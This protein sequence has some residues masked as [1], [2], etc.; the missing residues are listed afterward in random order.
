LLPVGPGIPQKIPIEGIEAEE[1]QLLPGGKGVL[2]F[3]T[4]KGKQGIY[5]VGMEGGRPT[6]VPVEDFSVSSGTA[7][8]PDGQRLAYI[9]KD[10]RL[11]TVPMFGGDAGTVPGTPIE[12]NA[13][14]LEWSDDGRFVYLARAGEVPSLIERLE[15][16]TGRR[17]PWKRLFPGDAVGATTISSIHI[18]RDGQSYVYSYFSSLNSALFLISGA[19]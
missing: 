6:P 13:E 9:S 19:R 11:K 8:S 12:E 15:I 4:E 7:V 10:R 3:G 1:A 14:L 17:E 18:T 2:V 16:S 5:V